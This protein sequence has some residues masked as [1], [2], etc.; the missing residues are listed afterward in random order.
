M[1]NWLKQY[2]ATILVLGIII[3]AVVLGVMLY[4]N[5]QK[6]E[7]AMENSYN[8][9]FYEFINYVDSMET[10]LAKSAISTSAEHGAETLTYVWREA[11][12]AE[13]YLSQIPVSTEGLSNAS[14]FLN[15]V[16]DY[17]YA[18]S[19]KNIN[20]EELSQEELENLTKMHEYSVQLKN[21]INELS[22]ELNNGTI[23]WKELTGKKGTELAQQV[24]N[25]SQDS[26][27]TI[28]GTFDDYTGLI[29][30]GAF[31]EH[32]TSRERKGLTGDEIDEE[33]AKEIAKKFIGEDKIKEINSNGFSENGN[34]P[35]YDFHVKNN[36]E[37]EMD[38][39]VAKKGGHV[40]YLNYNREVENEII[41][42]EEANEK[43]LKFLEERGYTNMKETYYLTQQG[44]VTI[45][46][47]YQQ[48]EVIC[49]PDLIKIKIALDDGEILGFESTGYL[50]CHTTR[51]L[52]ENKISVDQAREKINK[53]LEISNERLAIIP[54]EYDTEIYCWEFQGKINDNEFLVYINANTG[55]EEDILVIINTPNGTLTT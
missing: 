55:K 30:D 34:I 1:K 36:T 19:R 20:N 33:K 43:A 32:M 18:L 22:E 31:S 41:S 42:K 10:Y 47:A 23:S 14:K 37:N 54:T 6:Y 9:S 44:I 45:N 3:V 48:G 40:V 35:S 21:A 39:S 4:N 17:S 13:T 38:I 24:S 8:Y 46:Y 5:N 15:Q 29:Y 16:S 7:L 27:D 50:N 49:Y 52:D 28:E 11:N 51:N 12:L 2:G 25:I 53:N 26:F